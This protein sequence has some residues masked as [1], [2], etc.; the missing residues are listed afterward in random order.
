ML[1]RTKSV[2]LAI[3]LFLI[4]FKVVASGIF[5]EAALERVHHSIAASASAASQQVRD[6]KESADD[7]HH[8]VASL[9]LMSHILANFSDAVSPLILPCSQAVRFRFVND[10]LR[11]Q[12]FPDSAFKPPKVNG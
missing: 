7:K 9:N 6:S 11:A 2:V 1:P 12:H 10:S 3:C 8:Q 5:V 4:A